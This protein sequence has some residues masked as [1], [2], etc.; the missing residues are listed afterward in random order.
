ME[1]PRVI[2]ETIEYEN[3]DI[4]E[5]VLRRKGEEDKT[6]YSSP[7]EFPWLWVGLLALGGVAF[8]AYQY[9]NNLMSI[10][11]GA[12]NVAK[13]S[14]SSAGPDEELEPGETPAQAPGGYSNPQTTYAA[15]SPAPMVHEDE[16]VATVE[17]S[18]RLIG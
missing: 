1:T 5:R 11:G 16:Y 8:L 18:G 6:K 13:S 14:T 17:R 9:R 4:E 12:S 10:L 2:K 3:G 15:E 7:G